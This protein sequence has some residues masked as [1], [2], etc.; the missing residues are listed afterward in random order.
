LW[1]ACQAELAFVG[2]DRCEARREAV[3]QI[4]HE[5]LERDSFNSQQELQTQPSRPCE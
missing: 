5:A 4:G 3:K 1:C 2:C